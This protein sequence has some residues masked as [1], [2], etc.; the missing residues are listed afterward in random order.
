MSRQEALEQYN[1]ALKLGQKYYKTAI[2]RG[3]YPYLQALDE[4]L[5]ES[6]DDGTYHY[7]TLSP[8]TVYST[9]DGFTSYAEPYHNEYRDM[10]KENLKRKYE[11]I[12]QEPCHEYINIYSFSDVKQNICKFSERNRSICLHIK[13]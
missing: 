4:I 8:V 2:I 11:Q 9:E 7:G 5:D 13:I 12:Y 1:Y 6:M 3:E 10:L